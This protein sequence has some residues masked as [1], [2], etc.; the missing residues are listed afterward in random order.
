[1]RALFTILALVVLPI[2]LGCNS[3]LNGT[4]GTLTSPDYPLK[5]PDNQNCLTKITV[6]MGKVIK[7]EFATFFLEKADQYNN[8]IFDYVEI[9]DEKTIKK[10]CGNSIPPKF[11]SKNN[12]LNVKF[13]S[14]ASIRKKGF[15]ASYLAT[16]PPPPPPSATVNAKNCGTTKVAQSRVI[17]GQNATKGAWPWQVGLYTKYG[18]LFCGGSLIAPNWVVTAAHCLEGSKPADIKIKAGDHNT[19]LNEGTE[20]QVDVEKVI[21]HPRYH[22]GQSADGCVYHRLNNDVGLLKL[23]NPVILNDNV[24]TVCLPPQGQNVPVATRCYITGWGKI[25]HPG[26]SYHLLQQTMLPVVDSAVCQTKIDQTFVNLKSSSDFISMNSKFT[27]I[28][29]K[30]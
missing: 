27:Q 16:D 9:Y 28:Q 19:Q 11:I 23:A 10:Y 14:D 4:S 26:D 12:T 21:S 15:S 8:C 3:T 30:S 18:T 5:Y 22:V 17:A 29:S 1:M 20:Q 6:P 7:L 25:K 13:F 2:C 24:N